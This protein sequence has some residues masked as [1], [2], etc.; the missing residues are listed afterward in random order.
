MQDRAV[1]TRQ[2]LIVAAADVFARRGYAA[3]TMADILEAAGVT[4]GALYFHFRS[5]E[6]LAH[7]I[8]AEDLR[9]AD[10]DAQSSGS[11]LQDLIDLSHA[12]ATALQT[13]AV[14]R[15]SVRLAIELTFTPGEEPTGYATWQ[16]A[17]TTL[18]E[19]AQEHGELA[20]GVVPAAAANVVVGS[21][22]GLQLLSEA[23]SHRADLH[24]TLVDWWRLLIAGLAS[25]SVLPA[26]VPE[27]SHA[28][29][30]AA[31]RPGAG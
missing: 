3:A 5:K 20:P 7:A 2:T 19:R 14:A 21:F 29:L 17:A 13:I 31:A 26:L 8:F 1:L 30:E 16:G 10:A 25:P 23:T 11:P 6:D 9:F 18:L 27:G 15:A 22:T 4:K 24:T 12:F 28:P